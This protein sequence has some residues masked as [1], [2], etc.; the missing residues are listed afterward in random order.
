MQLLPLAADSRQE[1]VATAVEL[2]VDE[3]HNAQCGSQCDTG[4]PATDD[5]HRMLEHLSAGH[6][7]LVLG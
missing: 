5:P 3:V 4:A 2:D 7:S 1:L 6:Q